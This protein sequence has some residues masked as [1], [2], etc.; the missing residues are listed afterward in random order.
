MKT[1]ELTA[2]FPNLTR[3]KLYF[4]E[5][6]GWIFSG[7][8]P[9]GNGRN[10]RDYSEEDVRKIGIM[11][12]CYAA[13]YT[14]EHAYKKACEPDLARTPDAQVLSRA[15]VAMM[16]SILLDDPAAALDTVVNIVHQNL[17]AECCSIFL[18]PEDSPY[19]LELAANKGEKEFRPRKLRVPIRST[20]RGGLT[21]HIAS[22]GEIVNLNAVQ[23]RSTPYVAGHPP[24][25]LASGKC[26]SLAAIPLKD[27]KGRLLGL[28]KLE[29][30]KQANG[31]PSESAF[32]DQFDMATAEILAKNAVLV[33]ESLRLYQTS[34][35]LM[36]AMTTAASLPEYL[37]EVLQKG[38]LLLHADRG[39]I[40]WWEESIK[41]TIVLAQIGESNL[42]IGDPMPQQSVVR[43]VFDTG[44]PV[45]IS[46]VTSSNSHP[47]YRCSEQTRSE[48]AIRLDLPEMPLGVLNVESFKQ[49]GFDEEDLG[50]L[51][52]LAKHVV[53]AAHMVGSRDAIYTRMVH[54]AA[55]HSFHQEDIITSILRSVDLELGLD[56][57][58]IF[59]ADHKNGM[60]RCVASH[61]CDKSIKLNEFTY[62]FDALSFPSKVFRDKSPYFS[63]DPSS[64]PNVAQ[65]GLE[66]FNV[67]G[68]LVGAPLIFGNIVVG[69]L[70]CWSREGRRP[71]YEDKNLLQR[72]ARLAV[73]TIAISET[74]KERTTTME[75]VRKI[76]AQ[77]RAGEK[78]STIL[79]QILQGVLASD[80][81][82]AR[83]FELKPRTQQF[84]CL[85][86]LSVPKGM[87]A[88]EKYKNL[89]IHLAKSPYAKHTSQI[90]TKEIA[91]S[92][93]NPAAKDGLGADPYAEKLDK[94]KY[95]PWAVAPLVI[96]GKLYGYLAADNRWTERPISSRSLEYLT[97]IGAF[98]AQA[99]ANRHVHSDHPASQSK[100]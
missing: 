4:W 98:A 77:M 2:K 36:E 88:P 15:H 3:D 83:V 59:I 47:Y 53:V 94:P 14:P 79:K 99:I 97:F 25:H 58:A 92:I 33:L 9:D 1:S 74:E 100:S 89:V 38:L 28:L 31:V 10:R 20:P 93:R 22:A 13:G 70:V 84:V 68:P 48:M 66:A 72:F 64:D 46:D 86:S 82:R 76:L 40:I 27:R 95:L 80:F 37:N 56:T 67:Q 41:K 57:G 63:A 23:L 75:H 73:T 16:K 61:G 26:F 60:L 69:V 45:I 50:I 49:N 71:T 62:T 24:T 90:W 11:L 34:L 44:K 91:A 7:K 54:Q 19:E 6:R 8:S 87:E 51:R 55:E 30:K 52:R 39:D 35:Q 81:E 78:L 42:K 5:K 32:F 65:K 29:N 85:T 17:R 12:E 43:C 21:G 96:N 18:V